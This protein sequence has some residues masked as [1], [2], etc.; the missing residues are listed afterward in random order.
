MNEYKIFSQA[1]NIS[2]PWVISNI[3]LKETKS[4]FKELHIHVSL[5]NSNEHTEIQKLPL[6]RRQQNFLGYICYVHYN[7]PN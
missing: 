2:S 4:N 3:N 7:M 1:L 6:T 5:K